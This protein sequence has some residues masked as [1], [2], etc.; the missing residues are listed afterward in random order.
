MK[1]ICLCILA[2][3]LSEK[4]LNRLKLIQANIIRSFD[5]KLYFHFLG[6]GSRPDFLNPEWKWHDFAKYPLRDRHIYSLIE[7]IANPIYDYIVFCDDDVAIDIDKFVS[8]ANQYDETP[9]IF[10][11]HPGINAGVTP[12]NEVEAIKLYAP[13]YIKNRNINE[14]WMGFTTS[15]INKKLCE[16]IFLNKS[17][18]NKMINISEFINQN[19]IKFIC[20][21]QI[22]ILSWLLEAHVVQGLYNGATCW[23]AFGSS[24]LF[25]EDG[26]HF[27]IHHTTSSKFISTDT[28]IN[29]LKK[30]PFKFYEDLIS[31]LFPIFKKGINIKEW[32][33]QTFTIKYF[34][35]PWSYFGVI[36][37]ICYEQEDIDTKIVLKNN[38]SFY[39]NGFILHRTPTTSFMDQNMFDINFMWTYENYII[40]IPIRKKEI[41]FFNQFENSIILVGIKD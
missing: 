35:A 5:H 28:I 22:P 4:Y 26:N 17:I 33:G 1:N 9:A 14:M 7:E 6:E 19:A 15:F 41:N 21:V 10:T 34:W 40:G 38:Y 24:S 29:V 31:E 37:D 30:S 8:I 32:E 20:D 36:N 16:K 3:S 2:S 12:M 23:P 25:M 11:C 27:H 39:K 13:E 18:L